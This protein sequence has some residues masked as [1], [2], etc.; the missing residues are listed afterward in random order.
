MKIIRLSQQDDR[1]AWLQMRIGKI[2]GKKAKGSKPLTRGAD[3]TPKG[4]WS[5]L[6]EKVAVAPD[7]EKPADRGQRL[8]NE[9]LEF[10][11][12]KYNIELDL[13]PGMWVSDEDEDIAISPDGAQPGDRPTY[14]AENKSLSSADHLKYVVRD[15]RA[16]KQE[17]YRAIDSIPNDAQ[18]AFREQVIQYFVVNP[19][20]QTLYFTLYDDRVAIEGYIH[21]VIIIDRSDIEDEIAEQKT[22][23]LN[24]L[25]EVN[26]LIREMVTDDES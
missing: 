18:N 7:G 14:A 9:A 15:K 13:D 16:R 6:A 17:D 1:E 23:E 5:L 19:D 24:I 26:Q 3:R 10:T 12:K 8:E 21:H 25:K 2:T 20:L 22:H 11:A 4:L